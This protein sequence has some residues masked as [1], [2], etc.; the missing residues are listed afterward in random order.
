MSRYEPHNHR[1]TIIVAAQEETHV[2]VGESG[3]I[4]IRQKD[5][6]G[7]EVLM[8]FT[9]EAAQAVAAELVALIP[10]SIETRSEWRNA[11]TDEGPK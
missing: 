3:Y 4:V 5:P 1:D 6:Y 7:D 11:E 9:A 10:I 2:Y 8:Y